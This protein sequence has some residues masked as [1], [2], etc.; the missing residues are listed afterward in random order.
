M[1]IFQTKTVGQNISDSHTVNFPVDEGLFQESHS[2]LQN[3]AYKAP[4]ES[5]LND[6]LLNTL[7]D[8]ELKKL[9]RMWGLK[10]VYNNLRTFALASQMHM[11]NTGVREVTYDDIVGPGKIIEKLVSVYGESYREFRV[12]LESSELNITLPDGIVITYAFEF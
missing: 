1:D 9:N 6:S 5:I 11:L 10:T 3:S 2:D 12:Y 8:D 4:F 7:P